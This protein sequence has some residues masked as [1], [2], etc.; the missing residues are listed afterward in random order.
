[1]KS[2]PHPPPRLPL[3]GGAVENLPLGT[4]A[5]LVEGKDGHEIRVAALAGV[6]ALVAGGVADDLAAVA[7]LDEGLVAVGVKDRIP[8]QRAVP[9]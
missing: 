6:A 2:N 8:C 1:M 5:R 7:P 3:T 4:P 9:W